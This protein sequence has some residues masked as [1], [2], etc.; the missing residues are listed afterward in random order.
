LREKNPTESIGAAIVLA[1]IL[2]NEDERVEEVSNFFRSSPPEYFSCILTSR[3]PRPRS[4]VWSRARPIKNWFL[5]V[6]LQILLGQQWSF[7]TSEGFNTILEILRSKEEEIHEV[8]MELGLIAPDIE[9]IKCLIQDRRY[10]ISHEEDYG[11]IKIIYRQSGRIKSIFESKLIENFPNSKSEFIQ[12]IYKIICFSVTRKR[13]HFI[14]ILNLLSDKGIDLFNSICF[15]L[16]T[17]IPI[18]K[19]TSVL[20]QIKHIESISD[21]EFEIWIKKPNS[22]SLSRR[23]R[24]VSPSTIDNFSSLEQ[25][26]NFVKAHPDIA[27]YIWE[28][29]E[30]SINNSEKKLNNGE[31][32]IALINEILLVSNQFHRYPYIW[33]KLLKNAPSYEQDLRNA[34]L[35]ASKES[36]TEDFPQFK[37]YSFQLNLPLE[38][39]L[40]P[41]LVNSLLMTISLFYRDNV[42]HEDNKSDSELE[43]VSKSVHEMV[44]DVSLLTQIS[45]DS[46]LSI[47]IRAAA[48]LMLLLH[49]SDNKD[50]KSQQKLLIELYSPE[51]SY[52]YTRA[53]ITCLSLVT[54]EESPAARWIIGSLLDVTRGNYEGRQYLEQL[55]ALWRE[56]SYAPIQKACVQ[57]KWLSGAEYF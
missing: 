2:P 48:A 3:A 5:K 46:A 10:S 29:E 44:G 34:F 21:S 27:I 23:I 52:W 42:F 38:A 20:N 26:K 57:E 28:R 45:N 39:P 54:T 36:V 53:V 24:S 19:N 16:E 1:H 15:C 50:L 35:T 47:N 49:S 55:L 40:L 11:G 30:I 43:F 41:H 14:E 51:I 33:G 32:L 12:L 17:S 13:L 6:T 9:I 37:F 4:R 8:A 22:T 7:L 56:S 18:D 25:W 31:L